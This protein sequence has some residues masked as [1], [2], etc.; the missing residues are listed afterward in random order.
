VGANV[1]ILK[2]SPAVMRRGIKHLYTK[3]RAAAVWVVP[4]LSMESTASLTQ[5]FMHPLEDA[6][7]LEGGSAR[8]NQFNRI[9]NA[10]WLTYKCK[11]GNVIQIFSEF[12]SIC[13]ESLM[14]SRS[15]T[16]GSTILIR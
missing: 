5:A 11:K 7:L 13:Y 15:F 8:V 16:R 2:N 9:S 12:L 1:T 4:I 14:K 3:E 6:T 10:K